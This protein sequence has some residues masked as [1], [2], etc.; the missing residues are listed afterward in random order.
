MSNLNPPPPTNDP[1]RFL[2]IHQNPNDTLTR[3]F[4][5]PHTSLS[6]GTTH[7]NPITLLAKDLTINQ[8]NQ[9]WLRLFLPKNSTNINKKLPLIVFFHGSGFI[10]LSA[11]S[12]IFHN[13]CVKMADTV[14]AVVASVDYRLAPEHRLPAAYDDAM[15][16]LSFIRSSQDEWLT[17][18]VDFSKCFLMGNRSGA[19]IAYHAGLRVVEKVN[20]LEPLKIQGLILRQPFFGGTQRTESELRLENDPLC[21][22]YVSDLLWKLALPIGVDRDH[23]YSN[24]TALNGFGEKFDKIKNQGWKVLVSMNGGDPLVD[25]NK[26]LVELMGEKGVEVIKDFQEEGYHGDEFFEE[27]KGKKFIE[28]VRG[29]ISSFEA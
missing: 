2:K 15:E 3:N 1:Y 26:E 19:T 17:K 6:L 29:F 22:L 13:F 20:D 25:R 16:A 10:L 4:E 18:Y 12:T 23:E 9:T 28:L 14:E 27:S 11:A 21:P 5:G 24:L 8:S 7:P